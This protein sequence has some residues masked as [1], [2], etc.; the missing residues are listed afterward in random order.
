MA[1]ETTDQPHVEES[2][3]A[4]AVNNLANNV[5]SDTTN[6]TYLTFTNAKLAEQINVAISQN[7]VLT[8]LLKTNMYCFKAT[9]SENQNANKHQRNDKTR[10]L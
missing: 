10:G 8:E 6:L 7:K 9:Q 1:Y 5:T 2:H 4:N 3:M